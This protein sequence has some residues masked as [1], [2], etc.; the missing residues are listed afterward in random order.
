MPDDDAIAAAREFR[1]LMASRRSVRHFSSR[2]VPVEIAEE[3]ILTAGSAPSGANLQPWRFVLMTDPGRKR[4]LREA[5]EA[6]EGE[7][8][9]RRA[10]ED[11][12][13]ILEP[14]NTDWCKPFLEI[15]PLI[16]VVFEVHKGPATPRPYY[17]KESV[18][19]AVGM[20][21]ACLHKAGLA[22]LTYTPS[23][24]GFLNRICD[25]PVEERPFMVIPV[26][27]PADDAR[28]PDISRKP[29]DEVLVR[30]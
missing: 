2:P 21:L 30:L 14:L 6:N 5:A 25:R 11:W 9:L 27:H 13:A 15:A 3:A 16:I 18:G 24:M 26:G 19:I 10:S 1:T 23:P 17:V 22:T 7:F 29:L 8:Y 20:L 28:V 12:L 4:A